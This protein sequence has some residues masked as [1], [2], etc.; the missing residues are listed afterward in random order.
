MLSAGEATSSLLGLLPFVFILGAAAVVFVLFAGGKLTADDLGQV[1]TSVIV[2]LGGVVIV[3]LFVGSVCLNISPVEHF[4]NGATTDPLTQLWTDIATAE[5]TACG[6]IT[7]ADKFIQSDLGKP[8]H[9]NPDLVTQ[10]QQDA[11]TKAGGPLTD[12]TSGEWDSVTPNTADAT[13]RITRLETTVNGFTAPVFQQAYQAQNT[14]ES[15]TGFAHVAYQHIPLLE[16]FTDSASPTDVSGDAAV[17]TALQQRLATVNAT[18]TTQQQKFL[19]PIDDKTAALNRGET[20]DCDKKR[21]ANAGKNIA[22][23]KPA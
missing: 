17:I 7:R 6:Y 2:I 21:G 9:D 3:M 5:K 1:L 20:S 14:C 11:R 13:N 4:E 15:F 16:S 19:K 10:A 18:I 12:C 22:G 8:G 23:G